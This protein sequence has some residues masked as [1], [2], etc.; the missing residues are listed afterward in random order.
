MLRR[1][2]RRHADGQLGVA[3]LDEACDRQGVHRELHDPRL[4]HVFFIRHGSYRFQR[5]NDWQRLAAYQG[6]TMNNSGVHLLDQCRLLMEAPIADVWGDMQMVLSPGDTEDCAK[7]IM[8][9]TNGRVI[10]CE[11]FDACAAAKDLPGWLVLGTRG[12]MTVKS[13]EATLRYVKGDLPPLELHGELLVPE[14]KYGVIGGEKLDMVEETIPAEADVGPSFYD[15]LHKC[16]RAGA[17]P[18]VDPQLCLEVIEVME[19]ARVKITSY[20]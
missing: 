15:L 19:R 4:G 9:G 10:D 6:G 16:L 14:R 13:K 18:P 5:R 17:P 12:S 20:V 8:R 11:I 2:L 3:E 7:V 1:C